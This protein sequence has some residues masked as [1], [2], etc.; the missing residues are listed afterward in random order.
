M[1]SI[2]FIFSI[3]LLTTLS[4]SKDE[5]VFFRSTISPSQYSLVKVDGGSN[6][7]AFPTITANP[8]RSKITIVYREGKSHNSF[9]GVL[10]Q[11]ES[12]DRGRTWKNRKVIYRPPPGYDVRDPQLLTLPDGS[13]LCRFFERTSLDNG[14]VISEVRCYVSKNGGQ[15][16]HYLS[17]LPN[18]S[19]SRLAA[20]RGN[21]LLLEGMIYSVVYN[22]WGNSWLVKSSDMGRT[23]EY[24]ISL[25]SSINGFYRSVRIN[26]A[27]LGF[28]SGNIYLAGRQSDESDR[29]TL[30]G[31]SDDFGKSWIWTKL[32]IHGQ[33]PSL[34]PFENGFIMTYRD[35]SNKS[36]FNF[37]AVLMR[38]QDV[39]SETLTIIT[40]KSFDIGYGDILLLESSFLVCFYS[41]E[42]VFCSEIMYD[43]FKNNKTTIELTSGS[44]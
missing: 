4:C 41:S 3:L 38:D 44:E 24:I 26:E 34:T 6:L 2:G 29:K 25:E 37:E 32:S 18:I 42:G 36:H 31:I 5:D 27:S 40:S 10:I 16:Y 12:D 30:W 11:K 19:G 23:W 35:V 22:L 8:D 21:M 1:K 14:Q 43:V 28:Y 20:S 17:T 15:S 33:A 39:A 7:L 9:D 13:I